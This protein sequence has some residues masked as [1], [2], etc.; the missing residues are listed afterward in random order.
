MEF[1]KK[2]FKNSPKDII[3]VLI[4]SAAIAFTN[5]AKAD[6]KEKELTVFAT[7]SRSL[8]M[9]EAFIS[10]L[11]KNN[12]EN[13]KIEYNQKNES[14][15]EIAALS[16]QNKTNFLKKEENK[17]YENARKLARKAYMTNATARQGLRKKPA[18]GYCTAWVISKTGWFDMHGNAN[19]WPANAAA[20]GYKVGKQYLAEGNVVVTNAGPY[21]HVAY[22]EIVEE[23]RFQIS[24]YNWTGYGRLSLR[25]ISK[26]DP[27]I[28]TFITK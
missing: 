5:Y 7:Q 8:K 1:L 2:F 9:P 15:I 11:S 3:T 14:V 27:S 12:R 4:L 10:S 20:I 19:R 17:S 18:N 28:V 6:A 26:D 23:D 22:I 24:E 16:S 25:W 21:G 13:I